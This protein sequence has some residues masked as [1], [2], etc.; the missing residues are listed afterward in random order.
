MREILQGISN[1]Q[2]IF[3]NLT[4][5]HRMDKLTKEIRGM[6]GIQKPLEEVSKQKKRHNLFRDQ[7]YT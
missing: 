1:I 6:N 5:G 3:A 4:Q 7:T 2:Y